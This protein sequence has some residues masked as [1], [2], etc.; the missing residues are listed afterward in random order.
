MLFGG[1]LHPIYKYTGLFFMNNERSTEKK[2]L[3]R[4]VGFLLL[5]F[6]GLGNILG[7]G[8]YVLVGK[9]AGHAGY[10]TLISFFIA[11]VVASFTAFT[12]AE[13]SS[14][15][16]VAAG[17]AVYL[18]EGF[19]KAWLSIIAGLAIAM[20]G[21]LSAATIV[22]GFSGYAQIFLDVPDEVIIGI[23]LIILVLVAI[24]GIA[25]SVMTASF[26]TLLEIV[27]LLIIITLGF[28]HLD[29]IPQTL[30]TL[31]SITEGEIWPGII[32]GA[33]LAFYAFLGFEDM[34][35]IAEETKNPEKNMPRA[36]IVALVVSTIL[37]ALVAI[38]AL[39]IMSPDQLATSDAPLADVFQTATGNAP[40]LITAIS[41]SA[42]VNGALIQIIMATRIFYGMSNRDWLPDILSYI[43][44]KTQTPIIATIIVG[45]IIFTLTSWFPLVTLATY[46][47]FLILIVFMLVNLALIRIK[48]GPAQPNARIYSVW[49][50]ICGVSGSLLLLIGQMIFS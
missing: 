44:P 27:G 46:S 32:M 28:D 29:K 11:G 4:E 34:V 10:F 13:L 43:H 42:V 36:I 45:I 1:C 26:L 19:G 40:K 30:R 22:K 41:L 39:L 6:Y 49:V 31:P 47:S 20:A 3:S 9:V 14:R 15:F 16:P 23:V 12:Y 35:N 38:A 48:R 25:E 21:M 37:Y 18:H 24:W 2:S 17:V 5:C 7:A 8:I 33:F 50:P